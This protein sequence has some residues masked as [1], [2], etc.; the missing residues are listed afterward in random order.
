M[1]AAMA[2]RELA[3]N[4]VGTTAHVPY[5]DL[6]HLMYYLSCVTSVVKGLNIPGKFLDY[7]KYWK[8]DSDEAWNVV[9]MAQK[10]DPDTLVRAGV[11]VRCE[12]IDKLNKN[13]M[14][15]E[16]TDTRYGALAT[17]DFFFGGIQV[18]CMERMLFTDD[19]MFHYYRA[20]MR[21]LGYWDGHRVY[22]P[23]LVSRGK[24]CD[25]Q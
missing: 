5:A 15:F 11:F 17:K 9:L 19:W 8:L 7:N 20:P 1:A 21:G 24:R 6:A 3:I 25:V 4:E 10:L 23:K 22:R 12:L 18:S 2:G 14:F 16:I 13:N